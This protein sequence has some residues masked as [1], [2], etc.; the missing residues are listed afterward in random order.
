MGLD[1]GQLSLD[2]FAFWSE[3]AIAIVL[4]PPPEPDDK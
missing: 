2:E 4:T 1:P 3:R